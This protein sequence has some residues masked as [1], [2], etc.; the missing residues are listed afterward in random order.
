MKILRIAL[1]QI[2]SIVGNFKA[3]FNKIT[4]LIKSAQDRGVDIITFPE[5]GICGYPPEDLLLR[6]RFL[7][8]S[9][10]VL[11]DVIK[12]C[13]GINVIVGFPDIRNGSVYNA[14]AL[15][16]NRTLIGI[17]HKIEL[18][19]Y[20]VFDENRYFRPGRERLFFKI[21][22]VRFGI[23]ICED[24]WTNRKK[25]INSLVKNQV[26]VVLNISASPFHA[27]KIDQ[28]RGI[29]TNFAKKTDA[30]LCYTNMV[31]GQDELVFDGGSFITNPAREVIASAKR[32]E[33]DLL[34]ADIKF[35]EDQKKSKFN[36]ST[37][38]SS[39][40]DEQRYKILEPA[41]RDSR[42]KP[43]SLKQTP[44]LNRLE[45]IYQALTLG[46]RDYLQKNGFKKSV[47]GL[48]GGIDS[49]LTLAIAVKAIG[50]DNVVGV[51]MPSEYTSN[52]TLLDSEI[53]AR[54][55][56][57]SYFLTIPIKS[58]FSIYKEVLL[59]MFKDKREGVE[60]ENLQARIRGNL[61]MTLSN[62]YG[63]LVLTT[64]NKSET[65][66]GYSTLYGDTAGGFAVIKDVPKTLV[67]ELAEFVNKKAGWDIIPQSIIVR[68]PTAE[69]RLNQRD[70]DTL[71]PYHYLD[72]ILKA[73]VEEDKEPS[74]IVDFLDNQ[75]IVKKVISMVD[76]NE[77]KRRQSPPGVKITPKAFGKD[78]RLPI[79]NRYSSN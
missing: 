4:S 15:I 9:W 71:P 53:V 1:G 69:L 36:S 47:I 35:G 11:Q 50:A 52:E 28:R 67:Y 72:P 46:T 25:V 78:R 48:S 27:E 33:E 57:I 43:V 51:T 54:N 17:Y 61:L 13:K 76:R 41:Q 63:W 16:S 22:E 56:K 21:D 73:Y 39:S 24:I 20:G 30:Y 60:F 79:T 55:F 19:N 26:Q 37:T 64:G 32:F 40:L 8:D 42:C 58:I 18:P 6:P 62:R 29:V 74:E 38:Q 12:Q 7:K 49:A 75:K 23:T 44:E 59:P 31:G 45:E 3:N 77:Y 66:V 65:A 14:A 5:L 2:N 34:I 70:E 68:A 10:E